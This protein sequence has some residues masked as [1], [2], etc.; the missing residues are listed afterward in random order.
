MTPSDYLALLARI[1]STLGGLYLEGASVRE[2]VD[3]T[4]IPPRKIR[5]CL[6]DL[7][8]AGKVERTGERYYMPNQAEVV[9]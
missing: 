8:K 3:R 4:G 7:A 1:E 6:R 2:L 5:R 9:S